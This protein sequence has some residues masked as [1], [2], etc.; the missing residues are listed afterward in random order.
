MERRLVHILSFTAIK[1]QRVLPR[2]SP[3]SSK[4]MCVIGQSYLSPIS[5]GAGGSQTK[6]WGF[7]RV[8][9]PTF[10]WGRR[11]GRGEEGGSG[12]VKYSLSLVAPF[13]GKQVK[14]T[15]T[16]HKTTRHSPN[17]CNGLQ[18]KTK[19]KTYESKNEWTNGPNE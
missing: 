15:E 5:G 2:L 19:T 4:Y 7:P 8:G 16:I 1:K 9:M 11:I 6:A 13:F 14:T 3:K 18:P 10:A 12:G 17:V